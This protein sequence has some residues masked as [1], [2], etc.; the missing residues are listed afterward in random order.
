MTRPIDSMTAKVTTYCASETAK[1]KSG[2]TKEKSKTSTPRTL[3]NM[4]GPRP[5]LNADQ[6]TLAKNSITVLASAIRELKRPHAVRREAG[7]CNQ[8]GRLDVR[9]L[10]DARGRCSRD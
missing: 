10:I 5:N 4:A 1:V 7:D 2:G 9:H 6:A 3:A 8:G